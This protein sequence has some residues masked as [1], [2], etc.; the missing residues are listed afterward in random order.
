MGELKANG[1][2]VLSRYDINLQ[3]RQLKGEMSKAF[4]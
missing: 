4:L 3:K 2:E 1:G